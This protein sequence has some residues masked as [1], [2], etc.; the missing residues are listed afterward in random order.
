MFF[1]ILL[2]SVFI[3]P[4]ALAII[5]FMFSYDYMRGESTLFGFV[6]GCG[7]SIIPLLI[8]LSTWTKYADNL[9]IVGEQERIIIIYQDQ[10]DRL[11]ETLENFDFPKNSIFSVNMDNPISAITKQLAKAEGSLA[12]AK[13]AKAA[14]HKKIAATRIGPMSGV[15]KFVGE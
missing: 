15:I 13:K 5:F 9:A 11:T 3:I 14:A 12:T 4:L 6:V 2:Y 8:V 10:R 7:V 1:T